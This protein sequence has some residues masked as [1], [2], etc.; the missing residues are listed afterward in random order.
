[1]TQKIEVRTGSNNVFA[2]L[3]LENSAELLVKAELTRKISSSITQQ[4][5][6]LTEA[7]ELLGLEQTRL[8]DLINGQLSSFSTEQLFR[9]LNDLGRDVEIVVKAKSQSH[10]RAHTK[11]VA[12]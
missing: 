10:T 4:K 5:M 1:M 3:G 11:V 7:A 6:S 2:D 9:F 8:S 12:S